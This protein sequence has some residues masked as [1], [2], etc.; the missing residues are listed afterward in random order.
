VPTSINVAAQFLVQR[1][2]FVFEV[3]VKVGHVGPESRALAGSL[4]GKQKRL[5]ADDVRPEVAATAL[6]PAPTSL[7]IWSIPLA[8]KP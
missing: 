4:G 2:Q 6:E 8:A 7:P 3:E 5:E 1:P